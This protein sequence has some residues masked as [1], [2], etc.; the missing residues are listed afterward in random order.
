MCTYL[1]TRTV[2]TLFSHEYYLLPSVACHYRPYSDYYSLVQY[3]NLF[4][5][6]LVTVHS[7]IIIVHVYYVTQ[8]YVNQ[9]YRIVSCTIMLEFFIFNSQFLFPEIAD[10]GK[11][12]CSIDFY[13]LNLSLYESYWQRV[14]APNFHHGWVSRPFSKLRKL[15]N[16]QLADCNRHIDCK[17]H[18]SPKTEFF[19]WV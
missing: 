2:Q 9:V 1:H 6:Y 5:L 12:L 3:F 4:N 13:H 8:L 14:F 10:T 7:V 17:I 19:T 11:Q 18:Q 15:T 16:W